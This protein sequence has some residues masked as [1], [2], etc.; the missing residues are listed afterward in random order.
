MNDTSNPFSIHDQAQPNDYQIQGIEALLTLKS[1][2]PYMN[3]TTPSPKTPKFYNLNF[4]KNNV[5]Y[6]YKLNLIIFL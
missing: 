4:N 3:N 2:P 1:Y 6:I 5:N